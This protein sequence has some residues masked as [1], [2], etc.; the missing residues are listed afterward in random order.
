[1]GEDLGR[2]GSLIAALTAAY[3]EGAQLGADD[4]MPFLGEA[5]GVA[6]WDLTDAIDRGD[7]P[8]ALSALHRM[9]AGGARH[10]L[11]VTATLQR[12]YLSMLKLDGSGVSTEREAAEVLGLRGSTFPARKAMTQSRNLRWAGLSQAVE[13]LAQADLDLRGAS[14]WPDALVMDVLVARLCRLARRRTPTQ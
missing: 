7:T 5:G 3:G 4:V 10:P 1:L 2:L 12:H 11:V 14:A 13:L 8:A 9:L 6:P